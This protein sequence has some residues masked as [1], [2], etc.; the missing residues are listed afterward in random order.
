MRTCV[1]GTQASDHAARCPRCGERLDDA[2][3]GKIARG[4]E[5]APPGASG[6]HEAWLWQPSQIGR[7]APK[8]RPATGRTGPQH[9]L[10][11]ALG[12]PLKLDA[13]AGVVLVLGRD[14]T[15]DLPIRSQSVSRRHAQIRFA[16]SPVEAY[17]SD[18]GTVNGTRVNSTF[19]E[20]ERLL[21]PGDT[22]RLGDVTAVYSVLEA[23]VSPRTFD[24]QPDREILDATIPLAL[25]QDRLKIFSGDLSGDIALYPMNELLERLKALQAN[26]TFVVEVDGLEGIAIF[27]QGGVEQA[28][29][30]EIE[31]V[32]AY[33]AIAALRRGRFRFVPQAQKIR[34]PG[35]MTERLNR[36]PPQGAPTGK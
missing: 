14:E 32:R 11:P 4:A 27:D 34:P 30:G 16:G 18:L 5:Q 9:F 25:G 7:R 31:G 19:I 12:D 36:T 33:Q 8:T 6:L 22:V 23:G 24:A 3:R 15:C 35:R 2:A 20:G 1:C 10:V 26:G 21:V 29:L 17:L 28:V 13:R